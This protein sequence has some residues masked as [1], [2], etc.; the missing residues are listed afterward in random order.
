MEEE[1]AELARRRLAAERASDAV[2]TPECGDEEAVP[3]RVSGRP[4]CTSATPVRTES[5]VRYLR[6]CGDEAD[7]KGLG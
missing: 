1:V 6:P 2:L 4:S 5:Q 7:N 3:P